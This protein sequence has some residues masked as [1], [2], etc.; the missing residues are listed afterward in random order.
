MTKLSERITEMLRIRSISQA[1]LARRSELTRA[2]VND[3]INERSTSIGSDNLFNVAEA[4]SVYPKW[5]AQG[6]GAVSPGYERLGK[7]IAEAREKKKM[8]Q[9]D[10]ANAINTLNVQ[11]TLKEGLTP[12]AIHRVEHGYKHDLVA[13]LGVYAEALSV[14]EDWLIGKG[15]D[16]EFESM[17]SS[18]DDTLVSIPQLTAVGSMGDSVPDIL[19]HDTEVSRIQVGQFWIRE[20]LTQISATKNLR[21]I[22]GKGDSMEGT[23]NNG[24]ILFVDTGIDEVNIDAVYVLR[25]NGELFIKRLQRNPDGSLLMISDNEKYK[26]YPIDKKS[27]LEVIGAVVGIWNFRK[28]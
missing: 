9:G 20:N 13:D 2:A 25:F 21:M 6:T 16:I 1:E 7:R 22:T 18:S 12:A 10:L 23:F 24:D 4:L 5:L 3:W 17:L 27:D 26:P 19:D 28:L 15:E 8:S 11:T 14:E